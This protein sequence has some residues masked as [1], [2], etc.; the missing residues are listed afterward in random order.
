MSKTPITQQK[1]SP[2][3]GQI[4][5]IHFSPRNIYIQSTSIWKD[6]QHHQSFREKDTTSYP[7]WRLLSIDKKINAGDNSGE[8]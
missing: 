5:W 2:Q 6:I 1:Q 4:I 8:N 7:L 3:N